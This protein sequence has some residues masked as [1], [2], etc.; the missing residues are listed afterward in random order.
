MNGTE[1]RRAT[2]EPHPQRRAED[3][4]VWASLQEQLARIDELLDEIAHR[5]GLR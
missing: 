4:G 3:R 1:R 5:E 2:T